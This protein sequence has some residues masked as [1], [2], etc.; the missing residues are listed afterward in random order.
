MKNNIPLMASVIIATRNRKEFLKQALMSLQ[1]LDYPQ[2]KYEI[3]VVDDGST[4]GTE[5]VVEERQTASLNLNIQYC[6]QAKSGIPAAKNNGIKKAK[7][8][9]L[10]FIDDDCTVEPD[11]LTNLVRYFDSPDIGA[12]GGPDK[13][14]LDTPVV[15]KCVDYTV[16]SF[17]GTGGV[18]RQE[19][20]RLAKYYPRGCNMAVPKAVFDKAGLYDET[21]VAGEEIDLNYRVKQQGYIFKY[22]PDAFVWHKRREDVKSF[23][24]Q[25]FLRGYTRVELA[26]R[27][28]GLLEFSY[29]LPSFM[30]VGFIILS[31]LSFLFPVFFK[32]LWSFVFLYVIILLVAGVQA[33]GKI[34]DVRALIIE[35]F[36]MFLHHIA[37]GLGFLRA[38][39]K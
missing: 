30:V 28:I 23:W 27:H 32:I 33:M 15:A 37:Y 13:T 6:R 20:V 16:T 10:V 39:F 29:L 4:D 11:W 2:D 36:L 22:A 12:I 14:P 35:P 5:Q 9:L 3:I 19:G 7:G 17:I 31:G 18:R 24:N 34:K 26:R 38:L 21:L 25:I 1:N 8:D